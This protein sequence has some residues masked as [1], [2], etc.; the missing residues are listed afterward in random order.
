MASPASVTFD[1][2]NIATTT[3]QLIR[4]KLADT[5]FKASTVASWLL[6][7]G[8][9]KTESGGKWIE[10]PLAYQ[11]NTNT[12]AYRGYDVLNVAPTEELTMA[13][14][15]WRQA[16]TAVAISGLEELENAGPQAIFNLLKQKFMVAEGSFT[17]WFNEKLLALTANKDLAR[18]FLGLEEIIEPTTEA[19]QGSLGGIDKGTYPFWRNQFIPADI[20]TL[21]SAPAT[22]AERPVTK[23]MIIMYN[24]VTKN[25][26]VQPDLILTTQRVMEIY[27]KENHDLLR[28]NTVKDTN[29]M[30]VGFSGFAFKNALMR[31]D[32]DVNG[33]APAAED[34][35]RM[36]FINS[37]FMGITLHARRNFAVTP[38]VKPHN[39]DARVGQILLAGNM[40]SNNPRHLGVI[41]FDNL[42]Q[43]V[44]DIA[45]PG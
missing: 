35:H 9:V 16:A 20:A 12:Q 32:E 1:Y 17:E 7:R 31:W 21:G 22:L 8:R 44:G 10:E 3:L 45:D 36:Y 30:D 24:N 33:D 19:S 29:K 40:T 5:I 6:D 4:P 43:L 39:Q 42:D 23:M 15:N 11:K 38:M 41:S 37:R 18:D 34:N 27:E 25:H 26:N 14:Y 13:R 2:D 28:L